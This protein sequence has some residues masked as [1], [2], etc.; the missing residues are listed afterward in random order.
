MKGAIPNCEASPGPKTPGYRRLSR[1]PGGLPG[2]ESPK[3]VASMRTRLLPALGR[4]LGHSAGTGSRD[5][6]QACVFKAHG[7][8][9]SDVV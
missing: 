2:S 4:P 5:E 1:R 9:R 6:T 3:R 8:Y 7:I